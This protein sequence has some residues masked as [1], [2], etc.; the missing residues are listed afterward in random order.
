[1]CDG[2]MSNEE[3]A[4]EWKAAAVGE[5]REEKDLGELG[6]WSSETGR[7]ECRTFL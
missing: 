4:G 3:E 5:E 2:A 7:D 1:M 6:R